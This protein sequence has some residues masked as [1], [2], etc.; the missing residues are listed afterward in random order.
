MASEQ[1]SGSCGPKAGHLVDTKWV[2][3]YKIAQASHQAK[4]GMGRKSFK[5]MMPAKLHMEH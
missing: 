1:G 5:D 3:Q 4:G 2:H